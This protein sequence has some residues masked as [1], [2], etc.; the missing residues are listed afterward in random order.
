MIKGGTEISQKYG[1]AW[2]SLNP[3]ERCS[4]EDF[5]ELAELDINDKKTKTRLYSFFARLRKH[6][7]VKKEG[8]EFVKLESSKTIYKT[9]TKKDVEKYQ[10]TMFELGEAVMEF[11]KNLKLEI[12]ALK[13]QSDE[14]ER[15]LSEQSSELHQLQG[16][17]SAAKSK[18]H[19]LNNR[20]FNGKKASLHDLQES[21]RGGV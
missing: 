17:L 1:E 13:R 8:H 18:I 10:F 5:A 14:Y 2:E 21:L 12:S 16:E 11:I 6:G 7:R 20:Q 3:G 19:E 4:F 9:Q 15:E